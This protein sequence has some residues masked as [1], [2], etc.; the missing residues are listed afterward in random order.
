MSEG[1]W[2]RVPVRVVNKEKWGALSFLLKGAAEAIDVVGEK[3]KLVD[4]NFTFAGGH[5]VR[6][7][8]FKKSVH[9]TIPEEIVLNIAG[10]APGTPPPRRP[11][12]R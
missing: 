6:K 11:Q 8:R 10:V 9:F 5:R 4:E 1:E 3:V 12:G 7:Y 2:L